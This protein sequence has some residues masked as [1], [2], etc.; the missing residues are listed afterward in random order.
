MLLL[1]RF[2]PAVEFVE[3]CYGRIG[4]NE[5]FSRCFEKKY[6]GTIVQECWQV[7]HETIGVIQMLKHSSKDNKIV[8]PL[9]ELVKVGLIKNTICGRFRL[10]LGHCYE[11]LIQV[12]AG[13]E[14]VGE[15][16]A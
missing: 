2:K 9:G 3:R 5:I 11:T 7:F 8:P 16:S 12:D 15:T 1:N 14:F 10:S 13:I 4:N 6:G